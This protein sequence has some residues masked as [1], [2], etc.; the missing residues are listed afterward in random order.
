[1]TSTCGGQVCHC[2]AQSENGSWDEALKGISFPFAR[3]AVDIFRRRIEGSPHRRQFDS[4]YSS[5]P[6]G[7]MRIALKRNY[8][9]VYTMDQSPEKEKTIR[10]RLEP[11]IPVSAWGSE[12]TKN[13][14]FTFTVETPAQFAHFLKALGECDS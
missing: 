7:R 4:I 10:G 6:L 8:L 14:G 12:S 13:A 5:S 9:K 1:M 3:R 2:E 11:L